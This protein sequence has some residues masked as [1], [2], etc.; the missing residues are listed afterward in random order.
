MEDKKGV[1]TVRLAE[2]RPSSSF[3]RR[4]RL[5]GRYSP[6]PNQ[7]REKEYQSRDE[8]GISSSDSR[9]AAVSDVAFCMRAEAFS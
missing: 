7:G 3:P 5:Q 4:S 8:E 9:S 6:R 1:I 2:W